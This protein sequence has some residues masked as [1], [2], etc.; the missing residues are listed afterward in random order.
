MQKTP[1]VASVLAMAIGSCGL[2]P[3]QAATNY[4]GT[5]YAYTTIVAAVVG[6]V[7]GDTI[8]LMN[9]VQTESNITFN[10]SLTL[11]GLGMTNTILQAAATRGGAGK[12]IF[13]LGGANKTMTFRNMTFRYGGGLNI[14]GVAYVGT[15]LTTTWVNCY[16]T[17][18][19]GAPT[20]GGGC[21]GNDVAGSLMT[22]SN[23]IFATNTSTSGGGALWT[24]KATTLN[25]YN[26]TFIA[27][28]AIGGWGGAILFDAGSTN[29]AS[30]TAII[31]NSTFFGNQANT[32]SGYGGAICF[33]PAAGATQY[34]YNCTIYSNAAARGGG[35]LSQAGTGAGVE[36][37]GSIIAS[38]SAPS[39]GAANGEVDN[40][41]TGGTLLITNSLLM[42]GTL[43]FG[44]PVVVGNTITNQDPKLY[45]L[46][47]NGGPTPTMALRS[48]SPCID[49]GSNDLG[50]PYDQRGPGYARVIGAAADI[51]AYEYGAG[52][53]SLAYSTTVFAESSLND[54][55]INNTIPMAI[56]LVNSTFTGTPGSD[57]VAANKVL[58]SNMPAGLG[59]VMILTNSTQLSVTVTGVAPA[60]AAADS[61]TNLTFAFQN[62]AFAGGNASLVANAMRADLKITFQDSLLNGVLQYSGS[63]FNEAAA[64][65]G[66]IDNTSPIVITL[67]NDT[68]N[69]GG[70]FV[71]AGKVAVSNLPPGLTAM[72]TYVDPVHVSATLTG[73][74]ATHNASNSVT[75]LTFAFQSNAFFRGNA[76]SVTNAVN[77]TLQVLFKDPVLTY[78]GTVFNESAAND[79]TINNAVPI[80]ITLAGEA[81]TG[82]VGSDFVAAGKVAVTNL[83]SGLTAVIS[84]TDGT[85]LSVTLTG[86]AVPNNVANSVS[87][88]TFAFQN[89]AFSNSPATVVTN[90]V[91]TNLQVQFVNPTLTYSGLAFSETAA[92]TGAIDNSVPITITLAG[93]T[94]NAPVGTD[95][96]AAGQVVVT[97]LPSGLAAVIMV[98]TG[99]Q[100]SVTL[101]GNALANDVSNDVN[102]L[103]F[104]FQNSAFAEGSPAGI[105]ANA[106]VSNL[107]INFLN[108]QANYYV[109]TN[110]NDTTGDGSVG[111]PWATITNA[112]IYAQPL[113]NDI[114]HVMAGTFTQ[115]DILVNKIVTIQGAG[116]TNTVVQAA[117]SPFTAANHRV[118]WVTAN[119]TLSGMT[120]QN[121]NTSNSVV[122]SAMYADQGKNITIRNS[123]ITQNG[124]VGLNSEYNGG[125][126]YSSG[127]GGSGLL[128]LLHCEISSN[129]MTGVNGPGAVSV[130]NTLI[131]SN[132]IV[133]GNSGHSG[134]GIYVDVSAPPARLSDCTVM[135]NASTCASGA[136]TW[137]GGGI[138]LGAS[139]S[140]VERCTIAFN[141]A[142]NH[143]GGIWI[144]TGCQLIQCTIYS[145][146]AY[147]T[148][149]GS[150]G[151]G[152]YANPQPGGTASVY[153]C[154]IFGNTTTDSAGIGCGGGGIYVRY[155]TLGLWGT[156]VAGNYAPLN[157]PD[158]FLNN[159][160]LPSAYSFIG[161]NIGNQLGTGQGN[162]GI[163]TGMPNASLS[164]VGTTN[165][166]LS[167]NLLPLADNGGKTMTCA[168]QTNS[169]AI[170][171]GYN[172]LALATDQRGAGY[173]RQYGPAVDIGAFEYGSH[174]SLPGTLILLQ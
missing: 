117:S 173:A 101:T 34:V 135:S 169:L 112:L 152:I 41:G 153:N 84:K 90:A 95:L 131:A 31:A 42:G 127:P 15:V 164:Y 130:R 32:N 83:P 154:T 150:G 155:G 144:G 116:R 30:L 138:F 22:I 79:G 156:I 167:A 72:V 110:G 50:L 8:Q 4:V 123:R 71:A 14:S 94:F 19:D 45:P 93:D 86:T 122:G 77:S 143:G 172:P 146:A 160:N 18:N 1:F 121:G 20:Y 171:H 162:S 105:V 38:N 81:F 141:A 106:T 37:H 5:G 12:P 16:F 43:T 103:T 65:D 97:N 25:V 136:S 17:M 51:G 13:A 165:A 142:T 149:D 10:K 52:P 148:V 40:H 28:T 11:Q 64:N 108:A 91:T 66:S 134:G 118:F 57:F 59:A 85:H 140:V 98:T 89:T 129:M 119:A 170:D 157:G 75:N 68:F 80:T 70:E 124:C 168:L 113:G 9:P 137:G 159:G 88:L 23:C 139:S 58:V 56:T 128:T 104:A 92:N 109:A 3:A 120:I 82:V 63:V 49:H 29:S 24:R 73:N 87:N 6:S 158:L 99:T 35:I 69:A 7:D 46:A 125:A 78:G 21:L 55:T 111:N 161:N 114:I 102:N 76:A 2:H 27:N 166:V 74:A 44:L 132:C 36:I 100:A 145:N 48:D 54:G 163:V 60:N 151:G 53:L 39:D 61:I 33:N 147:G 26:S 174:V 126:I 96:V 62:S 107:S 47:Y 133:I 67:S 115:P